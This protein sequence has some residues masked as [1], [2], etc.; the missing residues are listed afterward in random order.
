MRMVR[1]TFALFAIAALSDAGLR[2]QEKE[3]APAPPRG[4]ESFETLNTEFK[5]AVKTGTAEYRFAFNAAV[6]NG[7]GKDFRFDKPFPGPLYSPRFLAIAEREPEGPDAIEALKMTLKTSVSDVPKPGTVVETRAKAIKLLR[8][9]HVEKPVMKDLLVILTGFDD[10]DSRALI[11]QVIAQHPDRKIRVAAARERIANREKLASIARN[12]KRIAVLEKSEGKEA[13]QERLA[14]AKDAQTEI[15][16]LKE[17]LRNDYS[18]LYTD[19]SVGSPAPE[20]KI[21]DIDGQDASL[22]ALRGKVVVLDIWATWCGPC[23]G[24][25]PHEREMVERLKDKPFVLV[26]ISADEKKETLTEF[27]AKEKMPWTHW[28]NGVQGGVVEDWD[29]RIFPT[30]YVLD[31]KGVIRYKNIRGEELEKAVN[32]LLADAEKTSASS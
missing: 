18:D 4:A 9:H 19:V 12:P 30:I 16:G 7:K 20:I 8:D 22:S 14:R 28:W 26:S 23:V 11:V 27:L 24:M 13:V 15:D 21:K 3:L 29:V 17:L 10:E 25:I 1:T 32:A 5:A 2:A 31:S 6:I